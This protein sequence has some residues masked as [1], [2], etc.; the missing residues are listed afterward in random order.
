MFQLM[1]YHFKRDLEENKSIF[2]LLYIIETSLFIFSL[3]LSREILN[4]LEKTKNIFDTAFLAYSFVTIVI[5]IAYYFLFLS[6]YKIYH[7]KISKRYKIYHTIG[8][9]NK[10]II[11]FCIIENISNLV[12]GLITG[13]VFDYFL[14]LNTLE[15][16]SKKGDKYY[17]YSMSLINFDIFMVGLLITIIPILLGLIISLINFLNLRVKKKK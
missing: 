10:Y 1:L 14:Y 8:L 4:A 11:S 17:E 9:K 16:I 13:S 12:L 7:H 5:I 3:K 2:F 15:S 6:T